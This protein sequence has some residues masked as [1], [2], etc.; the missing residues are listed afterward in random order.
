MN[1]E[2]KSFRML[3]LWLEE[4]ILLTC[5]PDERLK[6][7]N[8]ES[9]TWDAAF[10]N[11]CELCSCPIKSAEPLDQL[12]WLLGV[13]VRKAYNEQS[14]YWFHYKKYVF[15]I[16]YCTF[17]YV[18]ENKYDSETKKSLEISSDVPMII[19][20]DNPIDNLDGKNHKYYTYLFS[21]G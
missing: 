20:S 4:N 6:L 19:Q 2:E 12:E 16:N 1:L 3:I 11:Y 13:A 8:I 14:K 15:I 21:V 10:K 9:S 17:Y 18:L 5:K 7:Q